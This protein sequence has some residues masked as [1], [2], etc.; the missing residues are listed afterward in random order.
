MN[1]KLNIICDGVCNNVEGPVREYKALMNEDEEAQVRRKTESIDIR[2]R[3]RYLESLCKGARK[4]NNDE[5]SE[6]KQEK[7]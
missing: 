4:E 5:N 3:E 2:V 1:N 6:K 7:Q